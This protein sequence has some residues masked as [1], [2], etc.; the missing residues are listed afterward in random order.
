MISGMSVEI[1][2]AE[3]A[4]MTGYRLQGAVPR[5]ANELMIG[6]ILKSALK[7][8]PGDR[9]RFAGSPVEYQVTALFEKGSDE[10]SAIVM[11]I[12]GAR[13]LLGV[14]GSSAILLNTDNALLKEVAAAIHER[15]PDL[16]VK[17][18]RQVAVAEER[19]LGRIQL[20]MLLVTGVVLFSAAVA[21][22][23]TM[24]ATVIERL[25]EIGLMKAIGAS[26]SDI[27]R[28]FS[29]EAAL[30]GLAGS[31]GGFLAGVLAAEAISRAAF[32][33]FVAV[34]PLV[35]PGAILLGVAIAV[36]AT[37]V[38]VRDA[39]KVVPARILRGE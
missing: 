16:D 23:S 4:K 30:A 3:H 14:E 34:H 25:E 5:E 9:A 12:E 13:R 39:M 15:W 21:L 1:I 17:T 2:G 7:M 6:A 35:A 8:K 33:S 37:A 10:D 29:T 38:P 20:L 22:G 11:P 24:T 19:I 27:R 28:F 31:A 18:L 32:G 36:G 26:P